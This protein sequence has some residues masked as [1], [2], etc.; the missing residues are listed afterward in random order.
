MIRTRTAARA[1]KRSKATAIILGRS[2]SRTTAAA[3]LPGQATEPLK[4]GTRIAARACKRSKATATGF[5]RSRSRTTAAASLPGR[6]TKPLKSAHLL[7]LI[8]EWSLFFLTRRQ[9]HRSLNGVRALRSRKS[10]N[11]E[12]YGVSSDGVWISRDSQHRL[13]LPREYRPDSSAVAPSGLA[14]ALGCVFG[15]VLIFRFSAEACD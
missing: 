6:T 9:R 1:C 5:N 8:L 2:R 7:T 4:S 12:G 11:S 14:L 10:L 13:W 15:R 3:S